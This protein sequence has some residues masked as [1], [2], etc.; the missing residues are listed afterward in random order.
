MTAVL[1]GLLAAGAYGTSDFLGGLVSRRV[2]PPVVAVVVQVSSALCAVP[3]ALLLPGSPLAG[4]FAW[5]AWGGVASGFGV[6]FLFRGFATGQMGVVAPVSAVG[7]ALVPVGADLVLGTR[8]GLL[9]SAA[10][11]VAVPGLWLVSREGESA[12]HSPGASR[13]AGVLSGA[14]AG[15]GFGSAFVALD[16]LSADAG[17]WPLT[18]LQ[19][20]SAGVA[21]VWVLAAGTRLPR[22]GKG[23]APALV[24]GPLST[25]ALFAF[26]LATRS[27]SLT[28]AAVLTALY[29]A[30]TVL[31]AWAVLRERLRASQVAGLALCF[32]TVT[33]VSLD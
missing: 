32:T 18:L 5:A 23:L 30:A 27:G 8:P 25:L 9:T 2:P 14:L 28:V 17:L 20:V 6:L 19:A 22:S 7:T 12:G 10:V 11:A 4:D 21:T 15:V 13:Q 1:L 26:S 24:A 3:L 31:L 16:Q 29:P 33:L